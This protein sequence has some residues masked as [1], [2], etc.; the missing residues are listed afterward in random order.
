M[1]CHIA[2]PGYPIN[3]TSLPPGAC[4][5]G[6]KAAGIAVGAGMNPG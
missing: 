5:G 3:G 6:A 2:T 4:V 1:N